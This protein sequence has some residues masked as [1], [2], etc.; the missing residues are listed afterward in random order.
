MVTSWFIFSANLQ[1]SA[2]GSLTY[3]GRSGKRMKTGGRKVERKLPLMDR[4]HV[5]MNYKY[6]CTIPAR[7][8]ERTIPKV[9]AVEQQ[10][11]VPVHAIHAALYMMLYTF[12]RE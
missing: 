8:M 12:L 2:A 10:I 4:S 9:P 5:H 11:H 1:R 6:I 3:S 7:E